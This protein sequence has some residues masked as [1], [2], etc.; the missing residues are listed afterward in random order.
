MILGSD[1]AV[2]RRFD[3]ICKA[4]AARG[5]GVTMLELGAAHALAR[6]LGADAP[7]G[8]RVHQLADQ[9]GLDGAD[10]EAA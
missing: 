8:H 5:R 7:D 4:V 10:L 6:E 9:L 2:E 3:V 1:P